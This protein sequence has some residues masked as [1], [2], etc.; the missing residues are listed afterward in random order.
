M[1]MNDNFELGRSAVGK[2]ER[3]PWILIVRVWIVTA[4][5]VLP[6]PVVVLS[7]YRVA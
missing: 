6:V 3:T 5:S 1:F 2:S 4:V 7:A